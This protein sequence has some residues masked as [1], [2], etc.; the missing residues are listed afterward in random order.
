MRINWYHDAD[1]PEKDKPI[2]RFLEK[3]LSKAIKADLKEALKLGHN[4]DLPA[5]R[6]DSMELS[7]LHAY[8]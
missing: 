7:P 5:H 2:M 3:I 8:A 1:E 4:A 6:K